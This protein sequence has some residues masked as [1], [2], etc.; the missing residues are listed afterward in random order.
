[1]ERRQRRAQNIAFLLINRVRAL[2]CGGEA[3]AWPALGCPD[4]FGC[5]FGRCERI[6][7]FRLEADPARRGLFKPFGCSERF[8]PLASE[9]GWFAGHTCRPCRGSTGVFD[10]RI[11]ARDFSSHFTGPQ[12]GAAFPYR[13]VLAFWGRPVG[14]VHLCCGR[15]NGK[16]NNGSQRRSDVGKQNRRRG[17]LDD[18]CRGGERRRRNRHR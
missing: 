6:T 3:Y 2:P 13:Y 14:G 10:P 5:R 15:R 8:D 16:G 1:M 11:Q 12:P 17:V 18:R 4:D 9:N 7:V